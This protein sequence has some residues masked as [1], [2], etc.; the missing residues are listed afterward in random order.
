MIVLVSALSIIAALCFI[1]CGYFLFAYLNES[2]SQTKRELAT[3]SW[4]IAAMGAAILIL[5]FHFW[6]LR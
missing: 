6:R 5:S 4:C 3:I 2:S 1:I